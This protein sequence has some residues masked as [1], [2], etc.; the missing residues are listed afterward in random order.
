MEAIIDGRAF[1][2]A[3]RVQYYHGICDELNIELLISNCQDSDPAWH[4]FVI[5]RNASKSEEVVVNVTISIPS[6]K[7]CFIHFNAYLKDGIVSF[8]IAKNTV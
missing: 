8:I 3:F 2:T 6:G 4:A 5:K 7:G 1:G